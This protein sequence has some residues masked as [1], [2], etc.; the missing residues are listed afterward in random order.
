MLPSPY[1]CV[2]RYL[3]PPHLLGYPGC[4]PLTGV[5]WDRETAPYFLLDPVAVPLRVCIEIHFHLARQGNLLL[6]SPYGCVLRLKMKPDTGRKSKVAVPLR[7]CIEI[8]YTCIA[9]RCIGVAVPLRVCIEIVMG[10]NNS[11]I[12]RLP[13][14]YGCVLRSA[15]IHLVPAPRFGCRP[16]TGVYWD[17][18]VWQPRIFGPSQY[19]KCEPPFLMHEN[20]PFA[21]KCAHFPPF[22][23]GA[24]PSGNL[25]SLEVRT[26]KLLVLL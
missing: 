15:R 16:L 2:L 10:I 24:N 22:Y 7:V 21:W 14:P 5:Y 4:R 11:T 26:K 20:S 18:G 9:Y 12:H 3:L 23:G 6:P 1:G 25:C 17:S 19:A 8:T 13:S